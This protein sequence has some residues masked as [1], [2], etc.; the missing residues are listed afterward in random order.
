MG[1]E[2]VFTCDSAPTL[3]AGLEAALAPNAPGHT[4][5]VLEI[6]PFTAEEQRLEQP[7]FDGP[8]MK[9][10]FGRAFERATGTDIFGYRV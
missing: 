1:L 3:E 9:Y 4:F 8:E 7:P 6:E 10:R 5:V 2:R